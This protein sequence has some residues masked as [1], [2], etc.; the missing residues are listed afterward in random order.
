[1]IRSHQVLLPLLP[2]TNC[3]FA[4]GGYVERTAFTKHAYGESEGQHSILRVW[5]VVLRSFF[6]R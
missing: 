1:V 4:S 2:S 3:L 5:K 6:R